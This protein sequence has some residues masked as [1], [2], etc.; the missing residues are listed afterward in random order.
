MTGMEH[1]G[2]SKTGTK[3]PPAVEG[4]CPGLGCLLERRDLTCSG[5]EESHKVNDNVFLGEGDRGTYIFLLKR[6][7]KASHSRTV[8]LRTK[9]N[10]FIACLFTILPSLYLRKKIFPIL[11]GL[12]RFKFSSI[13]AWKLH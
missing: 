10:L 4:G 3:K 6:R 8:Y 11:N 7:G 1:V 12:W 5:N 13:N 2:N 9:V